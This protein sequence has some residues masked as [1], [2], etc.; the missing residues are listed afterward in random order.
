MGLFGLSRKEKETWA[1]IVIQGIKPGMQIDDALLKNATEI[2]ISQH[3]RILEDSIRLVMES[4]NQKTREERYDLSLQHF[5][6][7]S[8]IQ[9]FADKKQKKRIVDAQDQ[10]IIMN[11]HYKY[12]ERIRKQEKQE[13]KK[14][15]RDAFWEI[16]GTMEILDDIFENHKKS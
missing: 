10:F 15:K 11:E 9:K 3:I 7:L 1:S 12:P 2:Y 8:K 5:D 13:W 4:K 16:Y 6:A 14:Q